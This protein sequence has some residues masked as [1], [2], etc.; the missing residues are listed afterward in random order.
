[1][2]NYEDRCRSCDGTAVIVL[3][4]IFGVHAL[5]WLFVGVAVGSC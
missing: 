5:V 2:E 4:V 1:M 3:G